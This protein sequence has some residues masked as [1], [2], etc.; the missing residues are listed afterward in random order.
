MRHEEQVLETQNVLVDALNKRLRERA[1]KNCER[2]DSS[3]TPSDEE[4]DTSRSSKFP[5]SV[6]PF[7]MQTAIQYSR[8]TSGPSR[9][10]VFQTC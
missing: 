3:Y 10:I 2:S 9:I 6:S 1:T 7:I 4:S 5:S 8:G